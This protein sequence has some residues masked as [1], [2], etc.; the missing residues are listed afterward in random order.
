MNDFKQLLLDEIRG[1]KTDLK[2]VRSEIR[3]VNE[4]VV[5]TKME[6]KNGQLILPKDLIS[7]KTDS[8]I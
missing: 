5:L 1:L 8:S 3:G 7:K 4:E 2:E 6:F